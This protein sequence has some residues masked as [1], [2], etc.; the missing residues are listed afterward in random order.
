MRIRPAYIALALLALV[1]TSTQAFAGGGNK[2]GTAAADQLLI[3]VGARGIALGSAYT[4]GLTGVEAIYFNPAGLSGMNHGVEVL[5]SQMN[6][7]DNDGIS[8][9]VIGS[10]A[11]RL[12]YEST[13]SVLITRD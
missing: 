13:S 4:A 6:G 1:L 8:Y 10:N 12:L 11:E 9:F 2:E 3:P 5:F 7:L